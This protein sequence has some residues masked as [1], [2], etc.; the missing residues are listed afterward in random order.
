MWGCPWEGGEGGQ[1]KGCLSHLRGS[2]GEREGEVGRPLGMESRKRERD[3]KHSE[4]QL[5]DIY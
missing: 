4:Y 2:S 3:G 1:A 5:T